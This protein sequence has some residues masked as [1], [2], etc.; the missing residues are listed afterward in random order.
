MLYCQEDYKSRKAESTSL[1]RRINVSI[2]GR[3]IW[4]NKWKSDGNHE[5]ML[6]FFDGKETEDEWKNVYELLKIG[7]SI[8]S[9]ELSGSSACSRFKISATRTDAFPL[10]LTFGISPKEYYKR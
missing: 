5:D 3:A 1:S 2:S 10:A 6:T 4:I 9:E 8:T 7:I